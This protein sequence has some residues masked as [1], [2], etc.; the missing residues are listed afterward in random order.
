[1]TAPAPASPS[2]VRLRRLDLDSTTEADA[3]ERADL[4]RRGAMPDDT[5]RAGARRILGDVRSR[6]GHAVLE[7]GRQYGGTLAG[8]RLTIDRAD[9]RV[10]ADRLARADRRA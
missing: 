6:G 2:G 4:C 10:A 5:V 3:R 1:M 9:L 7:A 8:G